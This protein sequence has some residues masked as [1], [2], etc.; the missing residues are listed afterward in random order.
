[1][2][3]VIDVLIVFWYVFWYVWMNA[4][5]EAGVGSVGVVVFVG[6]YRGWI[7]V[8]YGWVN[9]LILVCSSKIR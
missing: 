8:V 2:L 5:Q 7:F 3:S 9:L 6:L 1:M 4:T